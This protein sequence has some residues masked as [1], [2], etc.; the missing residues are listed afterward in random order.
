MSRIAWNKGLH[1]P[2]KHD[3][4]FK[5]GQTPWNKG[6]MQ[7]EKINCKG[8]GYRLIIGKLNLNLIVFKNVIIIINPFGTKE[9]QW[10]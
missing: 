2:I 5:K 10:D 6:T 9:F 1:Y 7:M 8:C 4:Q 3:K